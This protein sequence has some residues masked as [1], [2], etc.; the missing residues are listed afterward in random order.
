MWEGFTRTRQ[1]DPTR[2]EWE[3]L[4]RQRVR[5]EVYYRE[6]LA[7]G[8]DKDDSI[9]RRRLQQKMEFVSDDVAAQIQPT[10]DELSA[11]LQAHPDSFRVEQKVTFRQVFLNPDK[12][13]K[14]LAHDAALLL[15]QLNQEGGKADISTLGD[16]I[17]L[18]QKYDALPA[19]EIGRLFGDKFA[20]AL[21]AL[22][23]GQWQGPVESAY[24]V[25]LV[26]VSEHVGGRLLALAEVHD[27]VH[28]E[29]EEASRLEA[30]DRFYR[31]LLKHYKVTVEN[32]E[33]EPKIAANNGVK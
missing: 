9:I 32:P 24:G 19:A 17:M 27:A 18:E 30:K 4:I 3:G 14:N 16:A 25:H 2:E 33:P 15:A 5:E 28:R 8:L 11:Y 13:G 31:E 7:L 22:P 12:H 23:P 20:T 1:R 21:G 26:F 29:W 10:D 6:A